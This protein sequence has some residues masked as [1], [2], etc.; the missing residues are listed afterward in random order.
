M[1]NSS[2][3]EMT[4]TVYQSKLVPKWLRSAVPESDARTIPHH[5]LTIRD[6]EENLSAEMIG[7]IDHR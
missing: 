6:V 4:A 2:T 7:P 5:P 1:E 3:V